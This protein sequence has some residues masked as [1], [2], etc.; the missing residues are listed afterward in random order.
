MIE[1]NK[2]YPVE[3]PFCRDKVTLCDEEGSAQVDTWRP[4]TRQHATEFSYWTEADA[5]GEMILTVVSIH[6]PGDYPTRVF[7]TRRWKDPDG[8]IFGKQKLQV[9]SKAAFKRM[10]RGYRHEYTLPDLESR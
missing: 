4:G 3:Y 9:K 5:M 6:R 7:F 1:E 8:K 10:L 2:T